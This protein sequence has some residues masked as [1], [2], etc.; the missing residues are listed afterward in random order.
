MHSDKRSNENGSIRVFVHDANI[1]EKCL[2]STAP[3]ISSFLFRQLG[4]SVQGKRS[5]FGVASICFSC[6]YF[7]FDGSQSFSKDS[8]LLIIASIKLAFLIQIEV[9]CAMNAVYGHR[10]GARARWIQHLCFLLEPI[11]AL[12]TSCV[13]TLHM[14]HHNIQAQSCILGRR[15][16]A[17]ESLSFE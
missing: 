14:C 3:T 10:I 11:H 15:L 5:M 6:R 2:A 17:Y 9:E 16:S 8:G 1:K 4:L 12:K 13:N 7:C